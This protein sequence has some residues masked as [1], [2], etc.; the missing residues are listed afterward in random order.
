MNSMEHKVIS[1]TCLGRGDWRLHAD[2]QAHGIILDEDKV[3][4]GDPTDFVEEEL[5]PQE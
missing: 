3:L 5:Q 2:I 4:I 1:K